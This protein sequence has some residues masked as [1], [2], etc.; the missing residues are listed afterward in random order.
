MLTFGNFEKDD[1]GN[2]LG[3][4]ENDGNQYF[5]AFSKMFSNLSRINP[6]F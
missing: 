1:F 5:F 6:D 3:I 4:G 2:F